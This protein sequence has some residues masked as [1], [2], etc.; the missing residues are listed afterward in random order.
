MLAAACP[1]A[2]A[3][4]AQRACSQGP[5]QPQKPPTSDK[6]VASQ[7]N[8]RALAGPELGPVNCSSLHPAHCCAGCL[9]EQ[10]PKPSTC[11]MRH[12]ELEACCLPADLSRRLSRR[13]RRRTHAK[14]LWPVRPCRPQL[15]HAH[16][17][18]QQGLGAPQ[19]LTPCTMQ[20]AP[21][22]PNAQALDGRPAI[23]QQ[24]PY[25]TLDRLP[26]KVWAAQP[27]SQPVHLTDPPAQGRPA[28]LPYS[29]PVP[30]PATPPRPPAGA[31]AALRPKAGTPA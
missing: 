31:P 8:V 30:P 5:R 7:V 9:Q 25:S 20:G 15:R 13:C 24:A 22:P 16:E 29:Q 28:P 6:I 4:C 14:I 1:P 27:L 10:H 21:A 17:L 2:A 3:P 26:Q 23:Q 19:S 11:W 12:A 18:L